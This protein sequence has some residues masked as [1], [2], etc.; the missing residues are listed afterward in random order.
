MIAYLSPTN[1]FWLAARFVD[2]RQP[3]SIEYGLTSDLL[4]RRKSLNRTA[5]LGTQRLQQEFAA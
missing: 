4:A 3:R 2:S 5:T 1:A